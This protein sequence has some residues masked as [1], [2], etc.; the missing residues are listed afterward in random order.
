MR[1]HMYC[2]KA[3]EVRAGC[4]TDIDIPPSADPALSL[5]AYAHSDF[6]HLYRICKPRRTAC[7]CGCATSHRAAI[8]S[9]L[10]VAS[11]EA[12]GTEFRDNEES[13]IWSLYVQAPDTTACVAVSQCVPTNMLIDCACWPLAAPS[14]TTLFLP[15]SS[16]NARH[17]IST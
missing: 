12:L 4:C 2:R 5:N 15:R 11:Q 7:T 14:M 6:Q 8:S 1:V 9:K 10:W 3:E 17:H 16:I 13:E